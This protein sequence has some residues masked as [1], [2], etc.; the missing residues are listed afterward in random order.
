MNKL[1]LFSTAALL[2][3]SGCSVT[4]QEGVFRSVQETVKK[5]LIWIKT[6]E[7]VRAVNENVDALLAKPLSEEN[8]VRIAMINNRFLQQ[9]Y[10]EIG[11]AHAQLVQA[12]LMSNPLLGYSLGSGD[13]ITTKTFSIELA[14]LDL[15]WIPLRKNLGELALEETKMRVGDEVLRIA[16]ETTTAFIKARTSHE[17]VVLQEELLT[18]YE[19]STQLS[20][21]QFAAGNLA[22]RDM[23]KIQ[24]AYAHARAEAIKARRS[25]ASARE[26]LNKIMGVYGSA[27]H[28]SFGKEG[29]AFHE[30]PAS[31]EGLERAAIETRLDVAAAKKR[32]EYAAKEA[33]VIENTRL[34]EELALEYE[35]EKSTGEARFNTL[36][37]KIPLPVFDMGQ[38]RVGMA[39]ARYN[40][41]HHQLYALAVN[42]RS[43]VRRSYG[44]LRYAYEIAREYRENILALNRDI[45]EQTGL[46]YNGM[47]D[48]IYELLEDQRR[49]SEA[50]IASLE[51]MAEYQIALADLEYTVGG[52][53]EKNNETK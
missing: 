9:T 31:S 36:G 43:E 23:L 52:V 26:A 21:R 30:P 14:F 25:A 28:Y 4:T 29:W 42:V 19:A 38:G 12:G 7:E 11:I 16:R 53:S 15:L 24:E 33:G 22:K 48:G 37:V 46:F 34:L 10:E 41:S 40:Q 5:D 18:S 8:A 20:I 51:A 1:L 44:E 47:L 17:I 32:L 27:T 50:K 45:L 6:P 39:Q 49:L 2:L 3:L 35:S 13:G